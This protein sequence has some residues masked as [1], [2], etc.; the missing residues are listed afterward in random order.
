MVQAATDVLPAAEP[1]VK[2]PG[3]QAVQPA[4]L[5]VPGLVTVPKKP[6]AQV[7]QAPTTVCAVAEP[8]VYTPAGHAVQTL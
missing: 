4:A 1:A 7:V 8:V 5:S 3:G 6:G 2:T